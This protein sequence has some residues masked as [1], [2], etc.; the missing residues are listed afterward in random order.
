MQA[1]K[2]RNTAAELLERRRERYIHDVL[3]DLALTAFL[4]KQ[5]NLEA[6][7]A[8]PLPITDPLAR[9]NSAPPALNPPIPPFT[10]PA[11][12]TTRDHDDDDDAD[13]DAQDDD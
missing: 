12:T 2:I 11:I 1:R 10:V 5:I 6:P 7:A 4:S 3:M 9:L 8:R 13:D